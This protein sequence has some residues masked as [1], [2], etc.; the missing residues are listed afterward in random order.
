[1]KIRISKE[2]NGFVVDP[3]DLPGSPVVGRGETAGEAL[4]DFLIHYQ[5]QLGI[6]IEVHDSAAT[7]ER[8]RRVAALNQR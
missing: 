4:G 2:S 3:V 7:V 8:L 1:M 6:E 5:A